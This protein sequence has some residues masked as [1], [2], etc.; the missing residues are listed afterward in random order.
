[1]IIRAAEAKD[2]S[3]VA[4]LQNAI[5]LDTVISFTTTEKSRETVEAAI[6]TAPCFLVAEQDGAVAG[7]VSYA[8][9]RGGDGYAR[10]MEHSIVLHP[11]HR[12]QGLGRA[13][14]AEAEAH[15]RAA[16]V[17]SLWAGVSGEHVVGQRFHARLGFEEI[18]RL[19]RV[20]F[21]FGRWIDLVLMQKWLLDD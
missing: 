13:L 19:P 3:A 20:G 17:G 18:A 2:A 11:E 16:G 4:A 10:A 5:I 15:A 8:Q 6:E 7:Y 1:M 21:K 12:G 9:F 14:M